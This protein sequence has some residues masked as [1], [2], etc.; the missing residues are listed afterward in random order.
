MNGYRSAALPF[1]LG[2]LGTGV[3]LALLL[4]PRS[5]AE[6]RGLLSQKVRDGEDWVKD[7]AVAARDKATLAKDDVLTQATGLRDR[8]REAADVLTRT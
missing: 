6:T 3:A 2:G 5:G 4:A 8:V 1:F 7:K